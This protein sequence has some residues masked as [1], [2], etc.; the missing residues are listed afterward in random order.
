MSENN[1]NLQ[2]EKTLLLLKHD[3]IQRG[4]IGKIIE[5]FEN[6]GLKIIAMKMVWADEERAASHYPLDEEWAKKVFEKTK[7]GYDSQ[8]KKMTYQ[9]PLELGETI[10]SWNKTFLSEGP[11]IALV[12]EGPHAVELSR[13]IVGNTEPRQALPGTIRGDFASIESYEIADAKKR[14]MRNLIHASDSPE[15]AEKEISIW[16]SK[17]EL[18]SYKKELDK[19]F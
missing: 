10:Q 11:V 16:F 15:N 9:T 7:K 4:L 1:K 3:S 6:I 5:R 8:G 2:G 19:H 14:V 18:F 13:K 17:N 12:L